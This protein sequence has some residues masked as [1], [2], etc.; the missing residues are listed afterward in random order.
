MFKSI[1]PV[2]RVKDV[3]RAIDWYTQQLGFAVRWRAENDGAGENCLLES[4]KTSLIVSSGS[5]LGEQPGFSGTL[6]FEM[7]GVDQFYQRIKD[8]VEIAWP[9]DNMSYGTREFGIRDPDGYTLAFVED[10]SPEQ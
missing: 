5:H 1:M 7:S 10:A 3:Q 2:L 9:L 4:G 6:Y 8:A